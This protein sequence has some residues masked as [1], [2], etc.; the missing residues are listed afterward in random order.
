MNIRELPRIASRAYDS[1]MSEQPVASA[2]DP[3]ELQRRAASARGAA[4][5]KRAFDD[6]LTRRRYAEQVG[7]HPTTLRRWESAGVVSPNATTVLGIP[8]LIYT[9]QDVEIGRRIVT[10]L[11]EHVGVMSL[12]EAAIIARDQT[13]EQQKQRASGRKGRKGRTS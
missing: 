1:H 11:A 4:A 13:L 3:R 8:T 2:N 9:D 7:I 10:L 6:L 12:H 5:V